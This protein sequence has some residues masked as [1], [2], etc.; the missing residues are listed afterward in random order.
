MKISAFVISL[1]R[2]VERR[3]HAQWIIANVPIPCEALSAVD[4]SQLTVAERESVYQ[5][6]LYRPRYPHE[7]RRGEIGCFLSHRK[8]WQAIVDRRLDAGVILED[9][10]VFDVDAMASAI[11]FVSEALEDNDYV[12]LQVRDLVSREPIVAQGESYTLRKPTYVPLRTTAQIVT[13]GAATRLLKMTT[14]FDRPVD[15]FLQMTW[16]TGVPI[17]VLD[18]CVVREISQQIGGSTLGGSRKP[19][20]ERLRR[21]FLRTWYRTQI[22]AHAR[23]AA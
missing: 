17:K 22:R 3:P 9:D 12:Q 23:R 14:P 20:H 13:H 2:A 16:L 15:T 4:G 6:N 21:E 10:V 5:R 11:E 19:W 7:L 1:E 18:P 8:A